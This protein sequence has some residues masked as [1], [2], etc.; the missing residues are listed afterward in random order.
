MHI[1]EHLDI[2]GQKVALAGFWSHKNM[3]DELIL[4][5]NIKLLQAQGKDIYV[6]AHDIPRIQSFL[7]QS[8]AIDDITFLQELPRGIRSAWEYF[9][10]A[11]RT[12]LKTFWQIDTIILWWGEIFTEESPHAYYYWL[13]SIR[14]ALFCRKHLYLMWGIQTPTKRYNKL[15]WKWIMH[16]TDKI[17]TRDHDETEKI[18]KSE[19][20]HVEFF[21]DTSY[22]AYPR[23]DYHITPQKKYLVVNINSKGLP[24]L[25]D[26]AKEVQTYSA[27][28]Y[29]I[30]YVPV[31]V[32]P[33]DD[34]RPHLKTLQ[35]MIG[36]ATK[37]Q[38]LEWTKDF[39]AFLQTLWWASKVISA[40]LH[41]FLISEFIWLSTKVYPYQ[42]KILKMQHIIQ[43]YKDTL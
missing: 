14:P 42:K 1:H 28:G 30:Y 37:I 2:R 35:K 31:C 32:G 10:S 38:I 29:D 41:L 11:K 16:H 27:Q 19:Y 17:Y 23:K 43:H 21:M 6:I 3:G 22:F 20:S 9:T 13:R 18:K 34:D 15:L 26:F 12:Q 24:F 40:R 4:L 7:K 33:S 25:Q 8:I 39:W 5:G 36:S